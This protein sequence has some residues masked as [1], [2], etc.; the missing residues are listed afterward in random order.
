MNTP[1]LPAAATDI[2][3][4]LPEGQPLSVQY[5]AQVQYLLPAEPVPAGSRIMRAQLRSIAEELELTLLPS[6]RETAIGLRVLADQ[7]LL[8]PWIT[9]GG[10]QR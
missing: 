9:L 3:N 7:G 6:R 2:L 8:A 4:L 5:L 1:P 10:D